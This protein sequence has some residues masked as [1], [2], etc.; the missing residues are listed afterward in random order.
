MEA[1]R[2]LRHVAVLAT[3]LLWTSNALG[4]FA[5]PIVTPSPVP[6][7]FGAFPLGTTSAPHTETYTVSGGS[8]GTGVR[9]NSV[10]ASGDFAVTTSG[11]CNTVLPNTVISPGACTV[12]VTFTPTAPGTRNG[13]LTF[14]CTSVA[15]PGGGSFT[16][17]VVSGN[18]FVPLI[19]DGFFSN[20]SV[21]TL[22]SLM[23]ALLSCTLIVAT[24]LSLKRRR[25]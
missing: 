16:C 19:G 9:V 3:V 6:L 2:C 5:Q 1:C 15:I 4:G 14:N 22:S 18:L 8:A 20:V 23:L 10:T 13:T 25:S 21:P 7:S 12:L 11:T 17:G 24:S